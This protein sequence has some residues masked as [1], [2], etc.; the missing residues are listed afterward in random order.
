MIKHS[1]PGKLIVFEGVDGSGKSLQ[2]N[3]LKDWLKTEGHG[4]IHSKRKQSPL[5]AKTI[6][7]AKK[8]KTLNY[9]TYSLIHAADYSEMIKKEII[10]ALKAGFIVLVN[11]YIYTAFA[12]DITRGNDNNWVK[13]LYEFSII[14][15]ITFYFQTT[16][17]DAISQLISFGEIDFYDAGMDMGFSSD[18]QQSLLRF[19]SRLIEQFEL[20]SEQYDFTVINSKDK[21]K[22]QQKQIR[23]L[24]KEIL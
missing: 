7:D 22:K 5:I 24:V 16:A 6:E 13:N 8:N 23:K 21:I 11:K 20:L 1:Y 15:D 18:P 9:I 12:R 4:V 3:L 2:L 14:P 10:P 19:Q 17:D